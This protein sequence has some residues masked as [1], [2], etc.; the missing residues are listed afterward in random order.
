MSRSMLTGVIL[1]AVARAA[2]AQTPPALPTTGQGRPGAQDLPPEVRTEIVAGAIGRTGDATG[3]SS[4][5][6]STSFTFDATTKDRAAVA[7]LGWQRDASTFVLTLRAPLGEGGAGRFA[8]LDGLRDKSM[9]EAGWQ[10]S[11]WEAE[12]PGPL[13]AD[14]CRKYAASIG[15][16]LEEITCSYLALLRDPDPKAREAARTIL[17]TLPV[18]SLATFGVSAS[19]GPERFNFLDSQTLTAGTERHT[20]WSF[21]ATASVLTP[22]G[23]LI[24][25]HY[26]HEV[27][28]SGGSARQICS[29]IGTTG[30][31]S[32]AERILGAPSRGGAGQIGAELR[33]FI[34]ERL[35]VS[36]RLRIDLS[37]EVYGLEVPVYFLHN[38]EGGFTGGLSVGWRSDDRALTI[39][40]FVGQVLGLMTR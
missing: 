20:N 6:P 7:R 27:A 39:V 25:G 36:P 26:R 10:W 21:T 23:I 5:G 1:L 38:T 15:R 29:P 13:L 35:A 33:A 17:R 28:F 8:D 3:R 19:I 18:T 31:L 4:A 2:A 14:I 22:R 12:D 34:S 11:R 40:A 30:S 24:A 16:R 37:R 9:V 32:C